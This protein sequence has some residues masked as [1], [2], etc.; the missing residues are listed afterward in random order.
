MDVK[1][2]KKAII[3]GIRCIKFSYLLLAFLGTARLRLLASMREDSPT[4]FIIMFDSLS[5]YSFT[6]PISYIHIGAKLDLTKL[7]CCCSDELVS[8]LISYFTS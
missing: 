1:A 4:V 6:L 5:H 7:I 3:E 8:E 2:A